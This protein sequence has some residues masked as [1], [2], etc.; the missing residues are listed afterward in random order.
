MRATRNREYGV[1]RIGG[2]NPSSS[3]SYKMPAFVAGCLE[4]MSGFKSPK[5]GVHYKAQAGESMP[6]AK[7]VPQEQLKRSAESIPPQNAKHFV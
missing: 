4:L 3:A 6:V 2:S 7:P 5:K 1:T